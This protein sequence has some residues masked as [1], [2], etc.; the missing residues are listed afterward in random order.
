MKLLLLPLCAAILFGCRAP[1]DRKEIVSR[2]D[3]V[4]HATNPRSPAQVGNGGF[5]FGMDI[6]GLQTFEPFNTLSDWG[7]H[8]FPQDETTRRQYYR[9]GVPVEIGGKRIY[10]ALP[11][12]TQPEISDWLAKN[13]HRFNLGRVGFR[14]LKA[15]GSEASEDDLHDVSQHTDLWNGI[16]TSRFSLEG[17]P[18]EV[19]TAGHPDRDAVGVEVTSP[20][21]RDGRLQL[22]L[23]FPYADDRYITEHVGNY[24]RPE[25]HTSVLLAATDT[26]A[27]IR[28]SMDTVVYQVAL[29]W[30]GVPGRIVPPGDK[31]HR[32]ML[33]PGYGN[34]FSLVCEFSPDTVVEPVP[35]MAEL[36]DGSARMWHDYWLSGAAIDLSE[37]EDSRWRELERRIVL[38][39]RLLRL[40]GAGSWPPQESGLVNNGWHGRFHFEM[41]WWH[42][43]HFLL[44]GRPELAEKA[45][46]IYQTF[47]PTSRQRAARQ[48]MR[49]ARWPK[50]TADQDVEWP[51]LIHATL[52]WQ[53]PHPIY[54]AETLYRLFPTM[55]TLDK[56]RDVVFATAEY[57]A[58]F[59]QLDTLRGVYVLEPPLCPVSEN[60][61]I[62]ETRNPTFEL[63]YWRYG[64]QTAQIWRERLGIPRNKHWD[65]VLARLAPLPVQE[66]TYV[67]YEGIPEMW[68]RY[69]FEHP[70]LAGIYGMLPGLGVDRSVFER[71][72][73]RI[74]DNWQFNRVWGWDFPLLAM[75][76]AR[77]G[78][79][80][81]AV[82]MLLYD[83]E[84]F[85]FDVHGL[86]TGG[87][88]PYFPSNG[89]LLTAVAMMAGGWEGSEGPVPGFPRCWHVK[90]EGFQKMQ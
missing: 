9:G 7:W 65:N 14:L 35:T 28:R 19:C 24:D 66:G 79:P 78:R 16:V 8:C 27:S 38:S 57:M 45:L 42:E 83:S 20:L 74:F 71:T 10:M 61:P 90:A 55:E 36:S 6:T 25:R 4:T 41:I 56:W 77:C 11:D 3:I 2:H 44:W 15:D 84:N 52:I 75:A 49:G 33:Q 72:L 40:N 47:L 89:G 34:R 51:H 21:L 59:I 70:A 87:P 12:E 80:G 23:D 81:Q 22:F 68:S 18:V 86:A 30:E 32:F 67:T 64:L 17:I 31:S 54:L 60:T 1:I 82:E 62:F 63:A 29:R 58:D 46:G 13:P 85:Q 26:T 5:A 69:N 48:G 76:A 37:S 43:L 73:D 50:C 39:Q 53:Q 88:F